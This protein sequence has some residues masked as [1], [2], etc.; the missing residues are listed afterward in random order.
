[1]LATITRDYKEVLNEL[2]VDS[3]RENCTY[4]YLYT[5]GPSSTTEATAQNR[6]LYYIALT[7]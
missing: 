5:F 7:V 4:T 3:D 6:I 1:M 2:K